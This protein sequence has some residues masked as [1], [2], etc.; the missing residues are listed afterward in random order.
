MLRVA[1]S[2][3]PWVRGEDVVFYTTWTLLWYT[4]KCTLW[5]VVLNIVKRP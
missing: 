5:M 2:S 3:R 4:K 1:K